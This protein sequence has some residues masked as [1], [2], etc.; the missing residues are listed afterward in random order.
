MFHPRRQGLTLRRTIRRAVYEPHA[1]NGAERFDLEFPV[2]L[3][4]EFCGLYGHGPR[5]TMQDAMRDHLKE[6]PAKRTRA[7]AAEYRTQILYPKV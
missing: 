3:R 2:A 7:N 1:D 5:R 6:C 4:C